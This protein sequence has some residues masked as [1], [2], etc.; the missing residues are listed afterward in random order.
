[1]HI[2]YNNTCFHCVFLPLECGKAV[3]LQ[4]I[5]QCFKSHRVFSRNSQHPSEIIKGHD[6][7]KINLKNLAYIVYWIHFKYMSSIWID[8]KLNEKETENKQAQSIE[9]CIIA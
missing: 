3:N 9:S 8:L 1:M 5:V 2:A 6:A 4:L 7:Y